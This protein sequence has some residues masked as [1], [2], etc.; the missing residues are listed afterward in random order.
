MNNRKGKTLDFR[1]VKLYVN[2]NF[3]CVIKDAEI[4]K[5]NVITMITADVYQY[6]QGIFRSKCPSNP[7]EYYGTCN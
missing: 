1:E 5:R 2:A 6:E 7:S 3:D 4:R